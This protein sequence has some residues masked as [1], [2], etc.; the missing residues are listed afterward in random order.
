[1]RLESLSNRRGPQ[2]TQG[3]QSLLCLGRIKGELTGLF[4][5]GITLFWDKAPGC[6][7]E[8]LKI[9]LLPGWPNYTLSE[10]GSETTSWRRETVHSP[11]RRLLI[12]IFGFQVL[13]LFSVYTSLPSLILMH[14][15]RKNGL[16]CW[17]CAF[18]H[19]EESLKI[20]LEW[21]CVHKEISVG[22]CNTGYCGYCKHSEVK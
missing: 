19:W 4:F 7:R 21:C 20:T 15:F 9:L 22:S 12:F 14:I 3:L 5:F 6:R 1:V 18:R 17:V 11:T 13:R 2:K 8:S 10:T 16:F